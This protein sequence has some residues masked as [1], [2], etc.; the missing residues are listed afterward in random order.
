MY[1]LRSK[2]PAVAKSFSGSRNADAFAVVGAM[3]Q[4]VRFRVAFKRHN[5][6]LTI[7]GEILP[8]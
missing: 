4:L 6:A 1:A 5:G 8:R 2:E 3:F 7:G